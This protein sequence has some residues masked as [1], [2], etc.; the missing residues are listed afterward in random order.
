MIDESAGRRVSMM[1]EDYFIA[2]RP[3]AGFNFSTLQPNY[4]VQIREQERVK[5]GSFAFKELFNVMSRAEYE[6]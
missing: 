6:A 4:G 1:E 5:S 2:D 3:F